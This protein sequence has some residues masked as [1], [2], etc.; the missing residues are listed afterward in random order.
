MSF[1]TEPS[2]ES[3]IRTLEGE[4]RNYALNHVGQYPEGGSEA[5]VRSIVNIPGDAWSRAL[6]YRFPPERNAD[7]GTPDVWSAGPN[8]KD[9]GGAGDDIGNW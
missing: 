5:L 8:Q 9:E 6:H 3:A 4:L 1:P 2:T 7:S